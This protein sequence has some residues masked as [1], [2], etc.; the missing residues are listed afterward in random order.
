VGGDDDRPKKSW[1]EID[2]S[3]DRSGGA[4]KKR[5]PDEKGRA[6]VEK[7]AAYSKYKSQLDKLFTPGGASL[8]ESM[9]EKLGPTSPE[10]KAIKEASEA[11]RA[12]PGEDTLARCLELGAS[13]GD[14]PRV[15]LGLLEVKNEALL[16]SVLEALSAIVASGKKPNRMLLIQK[17][18]A[19]KNRASDE[20]VLELADALRRE[21]D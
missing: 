3:R 11:L 2:A 16:P 10:A 4:Q 15:L 6:K 8:P 5:D 14:D 1:R 19:L 13:L 21:L 9:R 7:S 18:D 12:S 17:L 20:R